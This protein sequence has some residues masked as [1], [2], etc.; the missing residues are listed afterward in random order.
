MEERIE[1]A[2]KYVKNLIGFWNKI[3]W[4]DEI[5]V[6]SHQEESMFLFRRIRQCFYKFKTILGFLQRENVLTLDWPLQSPDLNPIENLWA[7]IK[8]KLKKIFSTPNTKSGLIDKLLAVWE[9]INF[10]ILNTYE[11]PIKGSQYKIRVDS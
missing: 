6:R 4:S 1:F 7:I 9:D 11:V 3:I 8:G 5:V 2:K 10:E